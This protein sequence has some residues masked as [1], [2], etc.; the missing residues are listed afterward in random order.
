MQAQHRLRSAI[1][2]A[3]WALLRSGDYARLRS[4]SSASEQLLAYLKFVDVGFHPHV[5]RDRAEPPSEAFTFIMNGRECLDGHWPPLLVSDAEDEPQQPVILKCFRVDVAADRDALSHETFLHLRVK[6]PCIL[7]PLA[8]SWTPHEPN[9]AR[10]VLPECAPPQFCMTL[11]V[12]R[13]NG[14]S[15]S[16]WSVVFQ[17][18]AAL[19]ALHS[20]DCAFSNTSFES[21]LVNS[22]DSSVHLLDLERIAI[23]ASPREDDSGPYLALAPPSAHPLDCTLVPV[24]ANRA[25]DLRRFAEMARSLV[26]APRSPREQQVL[27]VLERLARSDATCKVSAGDVL[28]MIAG[29]GS[30][31][32]VL[33]PVLGGGALRE[34]QRAWN[35]EAVGRKNVLSRAASHS[36]ELSR[37]AAAHHRARPMALRAEPEERVVNLPTPIAAPLCARVLRRHG[38][39]LREAHSHE[40]LGPQAVHLGDASVPAL[41]SAVQ[42]A[43]DRALVDAV[44]AWLISCFQGP[45]MSGSVEVKSVTQ[46]RNPLLWRQY[47]ARRHE[48][49][50]F[51]WGLAEPLPLRTWEPSLWDALKL[52]PAANEV[53]LFHGT[54]KRSA[55]VIHEQG[56]DERVANDR[57]LFGAGVYFAD[58]ALKSHQYTDSGGD[59]YRVLFVS[60]VCLGKPLVR[61]SASSGHQSGMR[62]APCIGECQG[63]SCA[64]PR[65]DSVAVMHDAQLHNGSAFREFVIYDGAQAYPEFCITYRMQ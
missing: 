25:S 50:D 37:E 49:A 16:N 46:V 29:S 59:G 54:K 18:F 23:C 61:C 17:L 10:L 41:R 58:D 20:A 60:R 33:L 19:H 26:G 36:L 48:L 56:F 6:H 52:Q 43:A 65:Y 14:P 51:A 62:R 57:G 4:G 45:S 27:S 39:T 1:A 35:A 2:G 7:R 9:V 42:I 12:L 64:H 3:A 28:K 32:K 30:S 53:L 40:Q 63:E 55:Q 44:T 34:L 38:D 24:D 22:G 13:R 31:E 5:V 8:V 47:V 21:I 15:P 11:P